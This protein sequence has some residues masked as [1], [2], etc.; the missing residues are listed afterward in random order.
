AMGELCLPP[1]RG[2]SAIFSSLKD[3]PML[4]INLRGIGM[5]RARTNPHCRP[6]SSHSRFVNCVSLDGSE[7]V[8]LVEPSGAMATALRGHA[9]PGVTAKHAHAKPWAWHPITAPA[10]VFSLSSKANPSTAG[11]GGY[12]GIAVS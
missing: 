6:G 10:E 1:R 9:K 8:V 5:R 4:S 7:N 3:R 12:L 2:G 11:C